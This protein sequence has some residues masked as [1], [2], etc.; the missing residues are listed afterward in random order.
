MYYRENARSST[1]SIFL[2]LYSLSYLIVA[3]FLLETG[4]VPLFRYMNFHIFTCFF[5]HLPSIL[6]SDLSLLS[7][8]HDLFTKKFC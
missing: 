6:P 8:E 4:T 2:L 5:N 7:L 3:V 1:T